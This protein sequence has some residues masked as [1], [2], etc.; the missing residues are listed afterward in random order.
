MDGHREGKHGIENVIDINILAK[1]R[2]RVGR[3][4]LGESFYELYR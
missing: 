2:Y 4:Q 1:W 3:E